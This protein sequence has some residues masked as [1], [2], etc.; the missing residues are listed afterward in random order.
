MNH[1]E[2]KTYLQ[3]VRKQCENL[4]SKMETEQ[5]DETIASEKVKKIEEQIDKMKHIL[6]LTVKNSSYVLS[7]IDNG[8]LQRVIVREDCDAEW[9]NEFQAAI[10]EYLDENS[11]DGYTE[12]GYAVIH[13]VNSLSCNQEEELILSYPFDKAESVDA[14]IKAINI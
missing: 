10:Q 3:E 8:L 13:R 5:I 12:D 2:I 4:E 14:S 11:I 7:I 1:L 9:K 6:S